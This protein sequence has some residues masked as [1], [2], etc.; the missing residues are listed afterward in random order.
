MKT[1]L[2]IA[3]QKSGRLQEGS[4]DLLK[5]SGLTI[6]NGRGQLKT[7]AL[8]FPV[9]ILFL[10]DDDIPQYIEDRVADIGIVGENIFVEKNKNTTL[11]KRLDF[12]KCRLSIAVPK[13]L[14]YHGLSSLQGKNIATS[15]PVIVRKY[16]KANNIEAGIHEISG[17]VEIAPGIGLADAICDIVSTG[18][19][20]LS[21]GLKE[22]E[23]VMQSEAIMIGGAELTQ[24]KQEILDRLLFR[25][26]AVNSA[27][28]N[29]YILLNCPNDA[30]EKITSVIPGMKSPTIM[31]LSKKNW[32][33]LHSVVNEN[34]FWEKID[35]L[36]S[37]GAEG[38]L[39]IPIEKMI[40]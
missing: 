1:Y 28:N 36:K 7:Q 17:S 15:Y 38:I 29:K 19:T 3:I 32:S 9:E 24:E 27:K 8:N 21:N 22:V 20:L 13:S 2:R 25:L 12:A 23:I 35:Q 34:D 40:Q 37:F 16:L 39:V 33:S 4:I 31:P 11:I 5:E 10:R 6:S 18:S 30:I 26:E 14:D